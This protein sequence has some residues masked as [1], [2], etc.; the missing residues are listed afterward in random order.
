MIGLLGLLGIIS[1]IQATTPLGGSEAATIATS[2]RAPDT[3][4]TAAT[5][6]ALI[7][8][9]L[10]ITYTMQVLFKQ[11]SRRSTL[12]SRTRSTIHPFTKANF[13]LLA[14]KL[15]LSLFKDA[16]GLGQRQPRIFLNR[17][18]GLGSHAHQASVPFP[19][20]AT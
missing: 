9:A 7:T 12:K 4:I 20:V 13:Y 15:A 17:A 11:R 10:L 2:A 6:V 14:S 5:M 16:V 19:N 1:F 8:T 3:A 18:R